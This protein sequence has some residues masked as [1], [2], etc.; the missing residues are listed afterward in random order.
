[1][2]G[3]DLRRAGRLEASGYCLSAQHDF[4]K[5]VAQSGWHP[6]NPILNGFPVPNGIHLVEDQLHHYYY[7]RYVKKRLDALAEE[8]EKIYGDI[9]SITD[10]QTLKNL[11]DHCRRKMDNLTKELSEHIDE[12]I[13]SNTPLNI[14]FQKF[15]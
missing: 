4:I 1:V 11:S 5:W 12:A 7:N 9:E 2:E 8:A 3:E 13:Q 10:K 6:S 15:N 14:F